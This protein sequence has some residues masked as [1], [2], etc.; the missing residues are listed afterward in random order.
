M[1]SFCLSDADDQPS[2]P[3]ETHLHLQSSCVLQI[4]ILNGIGLRSWATT[5]IKSLR[6]MKSMLEGNMLHILAYY[7][8]VNF[9]ICPVVLPLY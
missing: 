3:S 5:N 7:N 4:A 8:D 9:I 2:F 6:A 1:T